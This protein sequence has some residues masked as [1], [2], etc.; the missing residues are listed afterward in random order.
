[1]LLI[2]QA[3]QQNKIIILQKR[4]I[5]IELKCFFSLLFFLLRLRLDFDLVLLG[6]GLGLWSWS[7]SWS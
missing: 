7:W 3:S 2:G 5:E 6:L 1:M 4:H